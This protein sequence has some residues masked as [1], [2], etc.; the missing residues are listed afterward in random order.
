MKTRL[1]LPFT[2]ALGAL[3][4][5]HAY[6]EKDG[7]KGSAGFNQLKSL[8][9]LWEGEMPAKEV[10]DDASGEA[11]RRGRMKMSVEYRLTAG[12][13]VLQE[14]TNA[15]TPMEMVTMFH[16]TPGGLSLT[17]YCMLGNQPR[18]D[19]TGTRDGALQFTLS[20][21]SDLDPDKD[22]FMNSLALTIVDANH[23]VHRWT[24]YQN[25]QIQQ[26]DIHFTRVK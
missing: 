6:S 15:R 20:K 22:Q 23:L 7:D 8:V 25:G 14:T 9:G 12:G 4:S 24:M 19:Y 16:N 17:H 3:A 13:S 10:K 2:L 26:Q 18:M 5:A 1:Y 11:P 21:D